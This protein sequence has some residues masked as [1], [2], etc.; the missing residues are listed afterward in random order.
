VR[1]GCDPP[2]A[3]VRL[4]GR[5]LICW[6]LEAI[7]ALGFARGVIVA[8]AGSEGDF[9]AA[10]GEKYRVIAGGSTRAESV[11][12]GVTGLAPAEDDLIVIHDAARPFVTR[13]EAARIVEK[14]EEIGAAIAVLPVPDTVKRIAEGRV[15]ATLDRRELALA[16]TPQVFRAS[17]LRRALARREEATD[18]AALCE[19]EGHPVAAVTISRLGFKIT[20]REDLEIA[21]AIVRQ[22]GGPP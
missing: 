21:E 12:R 16:G 7:D 10:V 8:A 5:P 2:K 15:A 9:R 4:A 1:L 19:R 6:T 20:Y 18:E 13:D 3:L 14:A 22:R 17:L 11:R